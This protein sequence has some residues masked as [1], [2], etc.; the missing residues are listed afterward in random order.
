MEN[1][2]MAFVVQRYKTLE[3]NSK[4]FNKFVSFTHKD[5]EAGSTIL[6]SMRVLVAQMRNWVALVEFTL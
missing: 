4:F 2:L 1:A 6:H 3:H 5:E